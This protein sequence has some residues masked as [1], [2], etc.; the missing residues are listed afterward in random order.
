MSTTALRR[1]PYLGIQMEGPIARWYAATTGRDQ[2]RFL[3]AAQRIAEQLPAAS[4]V[5]E[6][7]PGPGY[8][9]LDLAR[10]GYRMTGLDISHSFVRIASDNAR[11]AGVHVDFQHGDVQ[12]MPF[13]PRS[14]DYVVCMAAFKNFPDPVAALNEMHR[15]LEPGG[16][17]SIIDMRK[18]ATDDEI[19]REVASMHLSAFN[20]WLTKLIFR[21]GLL[22]A[23]HTQATLEGFV[24]RSNFG[25]G[26]VVTEGVGYELKLRK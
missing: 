15:V 20:T 5:L 16:R 4:A 12:R 21:H 8:L 17:A 7:A 24:A 6:V 9:S 11:R 25:R 13:A 23:A 18:D 14:F 22:R 2:R 1:K 26:E 10:R 19:E 3:E